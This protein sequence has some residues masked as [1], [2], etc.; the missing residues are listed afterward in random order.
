[1]TIRDSGREGGEGFRLSVRVTYP[2]PNV[3]NRFYS[4]KLRARLDFT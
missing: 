1:L 3:K 2:V 4:G